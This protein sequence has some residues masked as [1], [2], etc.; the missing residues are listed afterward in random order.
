MDELRVDEE[1]ARLLNKAQIPLTEQWHA[2]V[3][4]GAAGM[5][6]RRAPRRRW[7]LAIAP[8]AALGLW[9]VAQHALAPPSPPVG[10]MAAPARDGRRCLAVLDDPMVASDV[11]RG[12]ISWFPDGRAI[13]YTTIDDSWFDADDVQHGTRRLW[14]LGLAVGEKRLLAQESGTAV[15][16]NVQ[17]APTGDRLVYLEGRHLK[18]VDVKTG[19]QTVVPKSFGARLGAWSPDGTYLAFARSAGNDEFGKVAL[20]DRG[21]WVWSTA[22][23]DLAKV[24]AFPAEAR[25]PDEGSL[26]GPYWSP[27]GDWLAFVWQTAERTEQQDL[28]AYRSEIRLVH[29][30][31]SDLQTIATLR[32][33]GGDAGLLGNQCWSPDSRA[34]VFS[35]REA[36]GKAAWQWDAVSHSWAPPAAAYAERAVTELDI[37]TGQ[38][39]PLVSADALGPG[40]RFWSCP[41][42][43]PQKSAVAFVAM[44]PDSHTNSLYATAPGTG[45]VLTV[46]EATDDTSYGGPVWSPDGESLLYVKGIRSADGSEAR[47][48][49][50]LVRL[51]DAE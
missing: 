23:G 36:L 17:V 14:W 13:T 12:A 47:A 20:D 42:W 16:H 45:M 10:R 37:T 19:K 11:S 39:T 2:R 5:R 46:A 33:A 44:R 28:F 27:D 43:S 40:T 24:V 34:L 26:W 6:L 18:V 38:M 32:R 41:A 9:L 3:L 22:A 4:D 30:D 1:V 7:A 31:G 15:L 21:I 49:L 48:E 50:W 51:G 25:N 35:W 29:P 8:A